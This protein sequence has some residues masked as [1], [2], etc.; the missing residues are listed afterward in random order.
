MKPI[1]NYLSPSQRFIPISMLMDQLNVSV[2]DWAA[3]VIWISRKSVRRWSRRHAHLLL[4]CFWNRLNW[5]PDFEHVYVHVLCIFERI[6][7]ASGA[8][9]SAAIK[10]DWRRLVRFIK[11]MVG[12]LSDLYSYI[13]L[14]LSLSL[15]VKSGVCLFLSRQQRKP[16][17]LL[18]SVRFP[19]V[20]LLSFVCDRALLWQVKSVPSCAS[21]FAELV[22]TL[23][24]ENVLFCAVQYDPVSV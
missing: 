23:L 9:D 13:S 5:T 14:I 6:C 3:S 12:Y 2:I 22:F 18:F 17:C 4:S 7:N 11:K 24:E 10:N 1:V 19:N 8:A 15:S 20:C 16:F 21:L